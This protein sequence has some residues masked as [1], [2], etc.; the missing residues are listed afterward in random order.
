MPQMSKR[1][2]RHAPSLLA[3]VSLLGCNSVLGLNNYTISKATEK[4]AGP[5]AVIETGCKTNAECVASFTAQ[6]TADAGADV[7]K[8]PA[9]CLK[10]E[11]ACVQLTSEDCKTVT[12]DYENDKAIVIGSL[13]AVQG[14]TSAQN[15]PR[16]QSAI[17]ALN[18]VNDNG[19][20]IPTETAGSSRPLVMVSCDTSVNLVRAAT[21]LV[22]DIKVPAIVGPNTSQDTLDVSNKVTIQ[23]GTVVIS[24]SAVASSIGD[25]ID[26]DLT[27][28]VVPSDEQRA[29]PMI[30]NI[31]DLEGTLKTQR[32]LTNIKLSIIYRND[33]LGIGTRTSM[34]ALTING[35]SLSSPLNAGNPS[36]NVH[37]D[38]YD[39]TQTDYSPILTKEV[40]F[41]PDIVVLAGTA[42]SVTK[43]L[44]PLEQQWTAP[45]RPY[46]YLI[47]PSKG[48]DLLKAVTGNDNLRARVR[49]TGATPGADSQPVNN[50]FNLDFLAK[51]NVS[52]TASGTGPSYD[53]TYAL[54][55]ALASIKDQPITGANVAKGLRMLAG[56]TDKVNTGPRD[57]MMAFSD[58]AS[59]RAIA[60]V[61]TYCPLE[62]D[63]HGSV[64]GGTIE[65]WCIGVSGTSPTFQSSGLT[66][67]IKT[68][69]YAGSYMQC[70]Q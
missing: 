21:H 58:L 4:D 64:M 31:N 24:P 29:K 38:P 11:G 1:M 9:I 15:L 14:T 43:V 27:W 33:A 70:G 49:G 54:A 7:E 47:D 13:F 53:A 39:A 30:K 12:G 57:I 2:L 68:Q 35:A 22:H 40:A 55:Y 10:D 19:G 46:Y 60:G 65:M 44:T 20:G 6:V 45:N 67:D 66:F 36:G 69:T 28:L 62:W 63:A 61:G 41:A 48:A 5:V 34:D 56:G 17:L 32:S 23:A 8:V 42:E 59:G 3:C 50:A 16:Q 25:L 51:Y 18:E 26:N 52:P 37:I